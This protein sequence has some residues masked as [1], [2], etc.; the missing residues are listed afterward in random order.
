MGISRIKQQCLLFINSAVLIIFPFGFC[1]TA[2]RTEPLATK[3]GASRN[4]PETTF[5]AP[6]LDKKVP[7]DHTV[8]QVSCRDGGGE[9]QKILKTDAQ[10][11]S[12]TGI[13]FSISLPGH[14]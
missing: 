6:E 1:I 3:T 10:I 5:S 11:N 2:D 4:Q 7:L 12:D 8:L 14:I 9:V 13:Y